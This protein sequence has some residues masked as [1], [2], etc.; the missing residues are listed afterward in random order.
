[1][2]FVGQGDAPG[3]RS[4]GEMNSP[5]LT[6]SEP[7]AP[8]GRGVKL[9][10]SVV[11]A[12]VLLAV[13]AGAWFVWHETFASTPHDFSQY[14]TN[15][16]AA[17]AARARFFTAASADPVGGV[18]WHKDGTGTFRIN[19]AWAAFNKDGKTIDVS[20][21]YQDTRFIPLPDRMTTAARTMAV[22]NKP[23]SA[24][25]KVS[26]EQ[27]DKLKPLVPPNNIPATDA[28]KKKLLD[29]WAKYGAAADAEKPAVAKQ[30]ETTLCDLAAAGIDPS[31][32]AYADFASK[33]R[34]ILT[35]EQIDSFRNQR[36]MNRQAPPR[37][38]PQP[39][40]RPATKP[41]GK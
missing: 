1:M 8:R 4:D 24:A 19:G 15:D 34:A 20:L 26:A 25:A 18:T 40:A 10:A 11:T 27:I 35:Q 3:R 22:F 41:A 13:G 32:R 33:V 28:D 36:R 29:L 12:I 30:L 17:A 7:A 38:A 2:Q 14:E 5:A 23:A 21:V 31:T 9:P 39:A 16:S 6:P 37:P